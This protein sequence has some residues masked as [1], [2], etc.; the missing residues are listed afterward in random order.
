M[1][2][3]ACRRCNAKVL[4][5]LKC[6]DCNNLF[7]PSCAKLTNNAV[8]TEDNILI[9]C[10]KDI[11]SGISEDEAYCA[12]LTDIADN[13]KIDISVVK[14]ML[15]QKDIILNQ[16]DILI[17]EL[18]ER[19]HILTDHVALL[20]QCAVPTSNVPSVTTPVLE[21]TMCG[22][23]R[24][25]VKEDLIPKQKCVKPGKLS[26]RC[27]V[28]TGTDSKK[29]VNTRESIVSEQVVVENSRKVTISEDNSS[30]N[31]GFKSKYDWTEVVRKKPKR[32]VVVGNKLDKENK[33]INLQGVPKS[34]SLHVFRLAPD[35][36]VDQSQELRNLKGKFFPDLRRKLG[37]PAVHYDCFTTKVSGTMPLQLNN[38]FISPYLKTNSLF[39]VGT[40]ERWG[41]IVPTVIALTQD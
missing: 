27:T 11:G 30:V 33:A 3:T 8:I 13:G 6:R 2:S 29:T 7:H 36:T 23:T 19:I 1:S 9:C 35:T 32:V 20:K 15:N 16:K 39:C 24:S 18:C 21:D 25:A 38:S 41:H 14:F 22:S 17:D 37:S 10:G 34:V 26:E 5:G 28:S 4:N 40:K 31:K 12:A